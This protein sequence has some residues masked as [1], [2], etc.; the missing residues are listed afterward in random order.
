MELKHRFSVM[1]ASKKTFALDAVDAHE[2][3]VMAAEMYDILEGGAISGG[4]RYTAVVDEP[5]G[6]RTTFR[7]S[8]KFEYMAE[9]L[10]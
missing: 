10:P 2:A 3:A 6:Q 8:A 5:D 4:C 7:L 9:V 1:V